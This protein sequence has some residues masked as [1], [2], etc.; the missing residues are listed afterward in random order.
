M[1]SERAADR[2]TRARYPIAG[3]LFVS[4]VINYLDRANLS[5]AAPQLAKDPGF[6]AAQKR[7]ILAAFGWTSAAC[8]VPGGWLVD[9]I[10]PRILYPAAI[11]LWS[12]A[13][14]PLRVLSLIK[15]VE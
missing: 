12:L 2:P 4:V 1:V 9:R 8:Q 6:V 10:P 13:K 7:W 5:V 11:A 15:G 14:M 3:M